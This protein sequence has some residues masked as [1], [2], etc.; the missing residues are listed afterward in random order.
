MV[1]IKGGVT[2]CMPFEQSASP[3]SL[4]A[5][6]ACE[7]GFPSS[8]YIDLEDPMLFLMHFRPTPTHRGSLAELAKKSGVYVS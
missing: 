3:L 7:N 8:K 4:Q 2:A 1:C 6:T 5:S